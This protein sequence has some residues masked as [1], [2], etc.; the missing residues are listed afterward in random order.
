[1]CSGMVHSESPRGFGQEPAL[2]SGSGEAI[3]GNTTVVIN[4][5]SSQRALNASENASLLIFQCKV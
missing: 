1:M 5:A 3:S 2:A 4:T